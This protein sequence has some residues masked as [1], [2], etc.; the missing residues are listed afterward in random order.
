MNDAI[1]DYVCSCADCQKFQRL[2]IHL[3]VQPFQ[4]SNLFQRFGVDI[5]GPISPVSERGH[6]YILVFV[7]YFTHWPEAVLLHTI[8]ENEIAHAVRDEVGTNT[9]SIY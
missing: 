1:V 4:V 7:E 3:P 5:I 8:E 9:V 6:R 2:N